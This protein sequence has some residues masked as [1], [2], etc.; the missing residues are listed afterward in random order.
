MPVLR[1]ITPSLELKQ[2]QQQQQQQQQ[3]EE[4]TNLEIQPIKKN[5]S[6]SGSKKAKWH[7][8]IRSQSKPQDIMNE[9][10]KAMK[11]SGMQWKYINQSIYNLRVRKKIQDTSTTTINNTTSNS[12]SN[13]NT[14]DRYVKIGLQLYQVDQKSYLLDF[15]SFNDK[16]SLTTDDEFDENKQ[17]QESIEKHNVQ[18]DITHYSIME[19]FE[20]CANL[21]GSL[22]R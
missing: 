12:N 22:A 5:T 17:K 6:G 18:D 1:D 11:S 16:D 2:Q 20:V 15:R 10:F 19:F 7:L 9:V 8:G 13:S 4:K 14:N 3:N 21:I